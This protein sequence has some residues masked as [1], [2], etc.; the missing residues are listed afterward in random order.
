MSGSDGPVDAVVALVLARSSAAV[1]Q[2]RSRFAEA[3]FAVGPAS[4]PTFAIEAPTGTYE[5]TFGA[6]PVTAGDGGWTTDG[7]DEFPLAALPA[8]LRQQIVAVALERP[9]ELHAGGDAWQDDA[10]ADR[11]LREEDR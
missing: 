5:R 10:P 6:V 2:V 3:G 4:G 9:V 1:D 11:G 7:G 8:E